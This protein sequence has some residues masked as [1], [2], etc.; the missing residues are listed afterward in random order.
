MEE[1]TGP[2]EDTANNYMRRM[3]PDARLSFV[4]EDLGLGPASDQEEQSERCADPGDDCPDPRRVVDPW[5]EVDDDALELPASTR[6]N[7]E[8]TADVE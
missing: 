1:Q 2:G 7:A 5:L 3:P 4:N 8:R 6:S